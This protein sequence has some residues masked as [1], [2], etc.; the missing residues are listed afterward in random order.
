[1][2]KVAD[3]YK[4]DKETID[5]LN[6]DFSH[7]QIFGIEINDRIARISMM[8]MVIHEDGHSNIECNDAL[9]DYSKLDP[10]KAIGPNKYDILPIQNGLTHPY[11]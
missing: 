8:D 11:R 9:E 6:W 4:A 2:A 3:K 5:R 10:K 7:K 1:M